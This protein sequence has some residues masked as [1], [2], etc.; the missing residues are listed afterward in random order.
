MVWRCARTARVVVCIIADDRLTRQQGGPDQ[1]LQVVGHHALFGMLGAAGPRGRVP[2][3]V[4]HGVHAQARVA[5]GHPLHLA[6]Q[7]EGAVRQAHQLIQQ[8]IEGGPRSRA[9]DEHGLR[10]RDRLQQPVLPGQHGLGNRPR[11]FAGCALQH[12]IDLRRQGVEIVQC[13]VLHHEVFKAV[14]HGLRC[15]GFR[16]HAHKDHGGYGVELLQEIKARPTH[17]SLRGQHDVGPML[18]QV[19]L[20][21][22]Q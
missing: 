21:L 12:G 14:P 3:K 17:R 1:R 22:C 8:K 5:V 4:G 19:L 20:G 16:A 15:M 10:P 2:A 18:R 6:H 13:R 7:A 11:A 9:G